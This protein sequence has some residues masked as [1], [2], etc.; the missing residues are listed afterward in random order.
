MRTI[1]FHGIEVTYDE[2][3]SKSWKWQKA[4]ASQDPVRSIAAIE[5]LLCGRDEEYADLLCENADPEAPD[6]AA[7]L[8]QELVAA[9]VADLNESKN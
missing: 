4:V 2:R 6:T 9:C 7:D 1:E 8:M 5:K 3:C